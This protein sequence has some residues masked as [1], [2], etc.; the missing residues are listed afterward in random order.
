MLHALS[1]QAALCTGR[2]GACCVLPTRDDSNVSTSAMSLICLVDYQH[3]SWSLSSFLKEKC[4]SIHSTK[5]LQVMKM[6]QCL[7]WYSPPPPPQYLKFHFWI[8]HKQGESHPC[9]HLQ[10]SRVEP[11]LRVSLPLQGGGDRCL[12]DVR[13]G[14]QQQQ[15]C[16]E[17]RTCVSPLVSLH[18]CQPGAAET[19]GLG[20]HQTTPCWPLKLTCQAGEAL[21]WLPTSSLW[22]KNCS[23]KKEN[24]G[25]EEIFHNVIQF[26]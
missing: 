12:T 23:K 21:K 15:L 6:L 22:K 26:V 20:L 13:P 3:R 11:P 2:A 10:I 17:R 25:S 4:S 1:Q 16:P 18:W 14:R 24:P 5:L 9:I 8:N 19:K 7:S